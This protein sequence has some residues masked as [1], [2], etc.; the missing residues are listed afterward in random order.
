MVAKLCEKLKM[1]TTFLFGWILLLMCLP[2]SYGQSA[3]CK[4]IG[5]IYKSSDSYIQNHCSDTVCLDKK[6]NYIHEGFSN[7]VVIRADGIKS[8]LKG[9][10]VYGYF[11]GNNT[12]RYFKT[13]EIKG[14][15]G[16]FKIEDTSGLVIYSQ[17]NHY[18]RHSSIS[19]FYSKGLNDP[20]KILD[21]KNLTSDFNNIDFINWVKE[22]KSLN[23][24][25]DDI[26]L[27]N[28]LYHRFIQ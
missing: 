28:E 25:I 14:P 26:F 8:T 3:R 1:K 19:Y 9:S 22:L 5:G 18:F 12:F 6:K 2:V 15:K 23:Q 24:K 13:N 7:K 20:I 10:E 16:Y 17:I 21:I 4:K 11:D 27:V